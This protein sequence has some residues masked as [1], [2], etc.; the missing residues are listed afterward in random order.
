[1]R[2]HSEN[3][4]VTTPHCSTTFETAFSPA[5]SFNL[6]PATTALDHLDHGNFSSGMCALTALGNFNPKTGGHFIFFPFR[7]VAEFPPGSTIIIPSACLNHGNTPIQDG[8]IRMSIAQYAAGGL[9]R[10]VEYGFATA[11]SLLASVAGKVKKAEID[12][13]TGERW[14]LGLNLFSK[15]KELAKDIADVYTMK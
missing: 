2:P 6:G 1:M 9:F 10:Y 7:I 12:M 15:H 14:R 4:S 8:E 11:K 3:C 5:I 13:K